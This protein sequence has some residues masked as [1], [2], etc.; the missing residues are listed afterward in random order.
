MHWWQ[1]V[2]CSTC[3]SGCVLLYATRWWQHGGSSSHT[4]SSYS[5]VVLEQSAV[6]CSAVSPSSPGPE[7]LSTYQVR[8]TAAATQHPYTHRHAHCC[9]ICRGRTPL[10]P[11]E[12]T[13]MRPVPAGIQRPPYADSGKLPGVDRRPQVHN[14]QVRQHVQHFLVLPC[15]LGQGKAPDIRQGWSCPRGWC[16]AGL[17]HRYPCTHPRW[18][19]V[20]CLSMWAVPLPR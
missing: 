14:A 19:M 20:S 13:P 16:V 17:A 1:G 4:L 10:Q 18:V 2:Q 15:S 9:L 8:G 12:V 3:L 11:F 6:Q 5:C 7:Q